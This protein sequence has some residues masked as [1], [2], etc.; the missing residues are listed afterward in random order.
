MAKKNYTG[1]MYS[2]DPNFQYQEE[3]EAAQQTLPPQQQNL[4]IFLDRIKGN[5]LVTRVNGFVGTTIDL[6]ALGKKLK[7]KCGVGG[8]V[9]D[10]EILLQGDF[11]DKI[12]AMLLADGYK[13]KK[14]GG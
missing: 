13:S 3:N 8:S 11:K 14:A 9:K 5:K 4:K 12:L 7:T 10:G 2:T 6:E 1:I